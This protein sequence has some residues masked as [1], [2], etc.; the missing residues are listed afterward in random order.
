MLDTLLIGTIVHHKKYDYRGVIASFDPVC[1]ADPTWYAKNRTQPSRN[2]R[3]YHIL[4]DNS[5]TTTYVAAENLEPAKIVEP[6]HHPLLV[7]FFFTYYHGR[8][9]ALALN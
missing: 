4:V 5:E 1:L 8:Y 2:Q 6:V 3:W 9:Y 7:H